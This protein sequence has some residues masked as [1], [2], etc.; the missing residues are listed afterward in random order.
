MRRI[1]GYIAVVLAVFAM[2]LSCKRVKVI[3]EDRL[4]DIYVEMF[5]AD[6][7]V[8][9]GGL[10]TMSD[11]HFVYRPIFEKY[12][13]TADDYRHTVRTYLQD[14]EKYSKVF[15]KVK[16]KLNDRVVVLN[17]RDSIRTKRDSAMKADKER[18]EKV[19]MPVLYKDILVGQFPSDTVSPGPDSA[20]YT[21][22]VPVLDTMFFGPRIVLRS[23]D[24]LR[25]DT[26]KVDSLKVDTT[27]VDTLRMK[28]SR[29]LDTKKAPL[30]REIPHAKEVRNNDARRSGLRTNIQPKVGL[31]TGDKPVAS[32]GEAL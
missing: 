15:T 32:E 20:R 14:P 16:D 17:R 11:T 10:A 19:P 21:I 26:L 28:P 7:W 18:W 24:S 1:S 12:G 23:D 8:V 13:Y 25:V 31:L 9:N 2:T 5:M 3:P 27:K 29:T 22:N 30:P 6:Q 4:T